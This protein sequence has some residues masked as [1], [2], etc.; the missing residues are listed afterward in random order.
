MK[1]FQEQQEKGARLAAELK[2]QPQL[3]KLI[4][5]LYLQSNNRQ[6]KAKDAK[7]QGELQL[8]RVQKIVSADN[9]DALQANADT[10]QDGKEPPAQEVLT[11]IDNQNS[12]HIANDA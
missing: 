9:H 3:R 5:Q 12:E 7:A 6:A 8:L 1:H 2:N 11:L 4:Q 10:K